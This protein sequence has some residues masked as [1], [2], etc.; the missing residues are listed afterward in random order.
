M[1]SFFLL[2]L[3][4]TAI[5]STAASTAVVLF[6]LLRWIAVDIRLVVACS[7]GRNK[8]EIVSAAAAS[9]CPVLSSP[10]THTHTMNV[11][12]WKRIYATREARK[13]IQLESFSSL[14]RRGRKERKCMASICA[15]VCVRARSL[16]LPCALCLCLLSQNA[17]HGRRRRRRRRRQARGKRR[18]THSLLLFHIVSS[19]SLYIHHYHH[20]STHAHTDAY[21]A[22]AS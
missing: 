22:I 8:K 6:P 21:T 12:R 2:L 15:Y 13:G 11:G 5:A 3:V 7:S 4:A 1:L 14:A 9:A 18:Q 20:H 17:A 10:H 19:L 16:V